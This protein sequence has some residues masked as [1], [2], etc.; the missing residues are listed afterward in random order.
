MRIETKIIYDNTYLKALNA[1]SK[2]TPIFEFNDCIKLSK[3]VDVYDGDTIKVCF[4]IDD[5]CHNIY[6]FTVR[7][8]GYN[9]EEIRHSTK[10]PLRD[11]KKKLGIEHRDALSKMVFD[12]LVYLEC[13]GYDK[14]GRLLANVFLD[15]AKTH[16][17]NEL[18]VSK[19]GCK[20]YF[21]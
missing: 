13:M 16:C 20:P 7:M 21:C 17:V 2:D 9:S 6:R 3:V 5:T 15:E 10:D 12:K 8:Y 18:M 19:V 11:D 4:S 1:T 14:Y